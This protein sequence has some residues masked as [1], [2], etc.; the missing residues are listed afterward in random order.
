MSMKYIYNPQ[1]PDIS[2][3]LCWNIDICLI[4]TE[5]L[6]ANKKNPVRNTGS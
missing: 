2:G 3:T 6:Y 1:N 4:P 5:L